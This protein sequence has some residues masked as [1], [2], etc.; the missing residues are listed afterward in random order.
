VDEGGA[1]D[2]LLI[3]I[4]TSGD[5]LP[6]PI[7]AS[8]RLAGGVAAATLGTVPATVLGTSPVATG[9]LDGDG[10]DELITSDYSGNRVLVW[11]PDQLVAGASARGHC[12][13]YPLGRGRHNRQSVGHAAR[14]QLLVDH[15][16]D[17]NAPDQD[18][19]VLHRT[20]T[21]VGCGVA[22][23]AHLVEAY[24]KAWKTDPTSAFGGI[25]A[26]NRPVDEA[27]ASQN[28]HN[29]QSAEGPIPPGPPSGPPPWGRSWT[30]PPRARRHGRS[31]RERIG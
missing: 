5:A 28:I 20:C 18:E 16:A 23:G 9:D 15:L 19:V 31:T 3:C 24:A 10:A 27:P 26:F 12:G 6:S 29:Q 30:S 25:L 2:V 17:V 21:R 8:E 4:D 13:A 11:G 22:V 14:E 1:D 7:L